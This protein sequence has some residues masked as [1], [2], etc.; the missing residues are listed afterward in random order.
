[1]GHSFLEQES[2]LNER[3]TEY[4]VANETTLAS[5]FIASITDTNSVNSQKY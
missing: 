2:L 4:D 5:F 3:F 1:M